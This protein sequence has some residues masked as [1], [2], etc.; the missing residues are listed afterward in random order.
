MRGLADLLPHVMWALAL[1]SH[2][3]LYLEHANLKGRP[4]S[5]AF[6]VTQSD[7]NAP[8]QTAT[9]EAPAPVNSAAVVSSVVQTVTGHPDIPSHKAAD[10]ITS[11]LAGLYQAEP[12]IFAVSRASPKTQAEV[13]LGFGLASIILNAFIHPGA[14]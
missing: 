10:V 2:V 6:D 14:A 3:Y 4:M 8:I 12:A 11:I 5:E 13:G 9:A 7:P 1:A